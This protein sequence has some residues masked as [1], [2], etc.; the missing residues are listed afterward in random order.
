MAGKFETAGKRTNFAVGCAFPGKIV[1]RTIAIFLRVQSMTVKTME[2]NP[3]TFTVSGEDIHLYLHT[4]GTVGIVS[5]IQISLVPKVPWSQ[6]IVSFPSWEEA[7]NG[8]LL[9]FGIPVI[10]F[11]NEERLN[12]LMARCEEIGIG[13][14]NP[15]TWDMQEGG[16][17][18]SHD[19]LWDLERS[20]KPVK[21]EEAG[22]SVFL[23]ASGRYHTILRGEYD[24]TNLIPS[25]S[26]CR[27]IIAWQVKPDRSGALEPQNLW[28]RPFR[29][30]RDRHK[31]G[32]AL[33]C[34]FHF[35]GVENEPIFSL[36]W[37]GRR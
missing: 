32:L 17:S 28:G 24:E 27:C 20:F 11:K 1:Q 10:L 21:P 19:R 30:K 12:R 25:N 34:N 18:Y 8:D 5:D 31:P 3:R 14:S 6:W 35:R 16:R 15:H 7:A 33:Y 2:V 26:F 36:F 23:F 9:V 13:V 22:G 4:Y 37:R 29:M